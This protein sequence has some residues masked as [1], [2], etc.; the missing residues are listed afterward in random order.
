MSINLLYPG[1]NTQ[2]LVKTLDDN[3]LISGPIRACIHLSNVWHMTEPE[4][5]KRTLYPGG[6]GASH[7]SLNG[8]N[9]FGPNQLNHSW[10]HW[11]ALNASNYAWLVFFAQDMCEEYP[12][13]F[14]HCTKHGIHRMLSALENMPESIPEGEWTEPWFAKEVSY[15]P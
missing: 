15:E 5:L 13:R 2:E 7:Y 9:I 6:K 3:W 8:V 10:T 14:P 4:S 1:R 12:K 11:A